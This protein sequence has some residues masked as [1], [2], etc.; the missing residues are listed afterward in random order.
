MAARK[1]RVVR[2]TPQQKAQAT[3][4]RVRTNAALGVSRRFSRGGQSGG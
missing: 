3:R 4:R 2:Q 1:R